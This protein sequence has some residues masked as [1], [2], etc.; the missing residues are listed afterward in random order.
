MCPLVALQKNYSTIALIEVENYRGKNELNFPQK[1]LI[2]SAIDFL[3]RLFE[4][5]NP[6]LFKVFESSSSANSFQKFQN[7]F[8]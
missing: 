4:L 1:L 3:K 8:Y 5:P 2:F 6:W 7:Y